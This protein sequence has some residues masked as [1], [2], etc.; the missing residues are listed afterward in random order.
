MYSLE[1]SQCLFQTRKYWEK[2]SRVLGIWAG[3]RAQAMTAGIS[4]EVWGQPFV[5]VGEQEQKE[6]AA[7]Y[8]SLLCSAAVGA[9]KG[10]VG[11]G[12]W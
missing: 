7:V 8:N 3:G 6:G 4:F 2:W 9:W 12:M 5:R 1:I 11:R 10:A